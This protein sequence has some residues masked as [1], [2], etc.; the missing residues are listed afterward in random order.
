MYKL[1]KKAFFGRYMVKWQNPLTIE[2]Q[3]EWDSI[4]IKSK[5][6][7]TIYGLFAKAL[8][9]NVKATIVLGHP[10]GKE[11]KGYFLKNGY[12]DLLRQNGYNTLVFDI[13]GFGESTHG[14]FSYFEDIVAIGIE[15]SILTPKI[16]IGYFGISLGGQWATIAFADK[17]HKYDFAIIESAATSLD[18]FWIHFPFAYKTL[19]ILNVFMP[20]FKK[21]IKMEERIKESK[22]LKSLLLIYSKTDDWTPVKMGKKFKNNSPVPTE[23]WIVENAKHANI[24]KSEYKAEYEKKI[25][26]YF[27]EQSS[28]ASTAIES[29]E[30]AE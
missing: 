23:L 24:M 18:D 11:A 19:K 15:A 1:I 6:G 21:K 10:M 5:S 12:T 7:G 29:V 20:K 25:I 3:K 17:T 30:S 4:K 16:P 27:N 28:I 8:T 22:H 14:N 2:Q 9:E 26:S 13:N